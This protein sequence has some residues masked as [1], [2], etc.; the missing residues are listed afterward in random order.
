MREGVGTFTMGLRFG[1]V[2]DARGVFV[3]QL[4]C[5][6]YPMHQTARARAAS[7]CLHAGLV[8]RG[9][10][11]ELSAAHQRSTRVPNE[12]LVP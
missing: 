3:T 10:P 1:M 9:V 6:R 4:A 8:G 5:A 2:L 12:V 11:G 7:N